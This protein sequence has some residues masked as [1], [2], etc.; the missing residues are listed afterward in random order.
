MEEWENSRLNLFHIQENYGNDFPS[1]NP[2]LD[3]KQKIKI[4]FFEKKKKKK[5]TPTAIST[6][7]CCIKSNFKV[8]TSV[9]R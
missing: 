7:F 4:T 1:E 9:T 6:D 2:P 5:K 8:T 3:K